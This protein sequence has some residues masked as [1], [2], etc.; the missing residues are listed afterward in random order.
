MTTIS[1]EAQRII[2][3]LA[4]HEW[5]RSGIDRDAVESAITQHLAE[6]GLPPQPV[7]WC[8]TAKDGY[9]AAWSAARSAAWSAAE[10]ASRLA[11]WSAA[12]SAARS[13]AEMNTLS[14]FDHP[15]QAK[16]AAIWLPMEKAFRNGLWLYWITPTNVIC[17]EQP[18]LSIEN[19]RLHRA[20]GP[21]VEW[22]AGE[23]YWFWR[24]TQV[25]Q[26]WIED[27]ASLDAKTA[28]TWPNLEQRRIACAEI[29]GWN[30]ILAQLDADVI[31]T[32]GD[33]Q[34]GT[35][36]EVSLPDLPKRARFLRVQCGT[37]REFVVGVAPVIKTAMAALAWM[38]GVPLNKFKK[39]EVRT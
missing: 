27:R 4:A 14:A 15:A 19:D 11:A 6:L 25:P 39:P 9:T 36:V 35:L 23:R 34:I 38:Q 33:P 37:G 29:V 10:S 18:S 22:P 32:D 12:W 31:D 1:P 2:N 20:D 5:K 17:V 3:S 28:L 16:L 7:V 24:G 13:A 8:E 21:A 30:R 26:E